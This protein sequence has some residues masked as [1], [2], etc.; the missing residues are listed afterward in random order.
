MRHVLNFLQHILIVMMFKV[1]ANKAWMIA[2]QSL[3]V[4]RLTTKRFARSVRMLNDIEWPV[5]KVRSTFVEYFEKVQGHV[6][7][8][9]S[10]V[11]PVNDPTLL[12]ANA[13]MNQFKPI[14]IGTVEPNSPL[15][16]LSRAV[17]SQKCIRAGGKHNDL[18]DVGK[19]TYH[20]TF[21]EM[22]GTWSFGDYFKKEAIDWAY[23]ILV[24]TYKLPQERLYA[25]YFGGDES[26]GLP[27]DEEARDLWLRY[28]PPERVLPFDKKA[29]FWEMGDTG[30][31]GP[32]SEIHFDRIGGR[33]ASA[34][35]NADDPNVI[36]IW[37]LVFIQY[38]RES[39]GDLRQLPAKHIDTGMGLERLTSILQSKSSNYDTDIFTPIFAEIQRV[40][41]C[42]PYTGKLGDEDAAQ[43]FKLDFDSFH[44][45]SSSSM[46]HFSAYFLV[47]FLDVND[48]TDLCASYRT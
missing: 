44:H 33:D 46:R 7:F 14:F 17:N 26:L 29:N 32:C 12:F 9:S 35:V 30:P 37:N 22:L 40:I 25:S 20:H 36:E 28:L 10:P 8:K 18:D 11:V 31:C 47:H 34:F 5:E 6:N 13:G 45:I 42:A 4:S 39:N 43:N 19:D 27:C 3:G 2:R 1:S 16:S 38:N 41:G 48:N 24:N 23:D 21:F 15:I